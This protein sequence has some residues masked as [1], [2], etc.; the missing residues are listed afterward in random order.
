MS[1]EDCVF[2]KIARKDMPTEV[3]LE[4]D[5]FIAFKDINPAVEGHTLVVPK[6]HFVTLLDIPSSWGEEMLDFTKKVTDKLMTDYKA[7]GFNLA[8]NNLE[9]A[10]QIVFHAH[11]HV[12]PRK[13][14]D[15]RIL[16]IIKK[17]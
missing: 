2:C 7:D 8:M 17:Q 3:V 11:I 16:D 9:A 10:G 4:S 12:F 13:E 1:K 14:G 15:G 5:R 6:R